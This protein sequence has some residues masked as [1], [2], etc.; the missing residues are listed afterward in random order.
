MASTLTIG[1][2]GVQGA[3]AFAVIDPAFGTAF[4]E[5][6]AADAAQVDEAV[7]AA[8]AAFAPWAARSRED[9]LAALRACAEVI[10]KHADELAPLLMREQGRP[11]ARARDEVLGV[12]ALLDV[13]A[14]FE[15][16]DEVVREDAKVR[17]ELRR[18]PFGVVAA[19]ATWNYP[20][21]VAAGKVW[22]ALLAGNTV[23]L[24]PSPYTPLAT[25]R[26]GELLRD[27]LPPGVLN[28]VAGSED[29]GRRLSEHPDVRK[30]SF[31]G[32]VA[33]GK[34]IMAAA[35]SDLKRITLELGGNDP[36]IVLADVDLPKV[37]KRLF[38]GAFANSGQVC[39]AAKRVYV[40]E[41][42]YQPLVDALSAI[43]R[44]TKV[45]RG[46]EPDAQLGPVNNRA[47]FDRVN[48][49]L[50]SARKDG[51][52]FVTGGEPI[53]GG[54]YLIAP[55]IVTGLSDGSRLV[56]EEQFGP[57]LPIIPV[58]DV[59]DAIERAN[60]SHFGL[61]GSIWTSDRKR[62]RE[63]AGRLE[64]GTGW[65]NQHGTFAFEAPFGGCKWSGI[66]YENGPIGL[67]SFTEYQVI[68]E[69]I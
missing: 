47:Q 62:A 61:G 32:S 50:E 66:G 60:S 10:A 51:A 43:A 11:L 65:I 42:A 38:W 20:L 5:S 28:V 4:A 67:E 54:G 9:R 13:T 34:K 1:G 44:A 21:M 57:A 18:K 24:K 12:S 55:S 22:P 31:T 40:E 30:I 59:D 17:V 15:L 27:T 39:V 14:Q 45:G 64:C 8:Q 26:V 23:V 7:E 49:L 53:P 19:I 33:V 68:S 52:T 35:A 29:V 69:A 36:A 37:A 2:R 58:H 48:D 6:P 41:S 63:L 16:R 46:A 56:D 25:L 3:T